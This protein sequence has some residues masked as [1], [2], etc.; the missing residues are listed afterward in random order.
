MGAMA[1]D[2]KIWVELAP[3]KRK[4]QRCDGEISKGVMF[5]RM[6]SQQKARGSSSMCATCFEAVMGDLSDGFSTMKG[7][8]PEPREELEMVDRGP[9]CFACGLSP[10]RCQCGREAYR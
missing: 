9:H 8:T 2:F 5:V 3:R 7:A 10:E 4:C 1:K 6:G